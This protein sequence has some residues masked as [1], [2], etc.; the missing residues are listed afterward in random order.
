[1]TQ[2]L[3]PLLRLKADTD[4]ELIDKYR[5]IYIETYVTARDRA[6]IEIF[7]WNG[8]RV[9]F[10]ASSFDHAFSEGSNYRTNPEHD[11]GFSKDRARRILWIKEVLQAS[12]GTIERLSQLREDSRGRKVQRR[13]LLVLEENYVV[14]L[15]TISKSTDMEFI[16]AFPAGKSFVEKLRKTCGLLEIK[17]PQS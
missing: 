8:R 17:K 3:W 10:R 14:V 11:A 13:V 2:H 4:D 9:L 5:N 16:S 12:A 15:Q 7:D 6:P 1:M